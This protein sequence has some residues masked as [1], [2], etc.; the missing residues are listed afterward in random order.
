M[1]HVKP[2]TKRK[3]A[4]TSNSASHGP[5]ST[6]RA[7]KR[8]KTHDARQIAVQSSD[9]ALK[10]GELDV[11]RFVKAREWEIRALEAGMKGAKYARPHLAMLVLCKAWT[12]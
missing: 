4:A 12:C 8:A 3:V 1:Q 9:K 2:A 7:R 5:S 10:N 11:D 6:P